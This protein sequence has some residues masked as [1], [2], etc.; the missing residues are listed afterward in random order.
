MECKPEFG[1]REGL[2]ETGV[3]LL[4]PVN[5][6]TVLFSL[7]AA[8]AVPVITD[9][10]LEVMLIHCLHIIHCVCVSGY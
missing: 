2:Q 1:E 9:C 4:N 7:S 8:A 3:Q 5:E 10:L 6:R